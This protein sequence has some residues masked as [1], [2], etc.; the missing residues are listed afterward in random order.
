MCLKNTH[1]KWGGISQ[2]FHW[3]MFVILV[4]LYTIAYIMQDLPNDETKWW[5]YGIHKEVGVTML[6]LVAARLWW[7]EANPIPLDST[8]APHWQNLL[9]RA[10][11]I[12]LYILLF[13]F[14]LSGL[15]MSLLGGHNVNYFGLFTIPALSEDSTPVGS[16]LHATHIY[17]SYLL[18]AFVA[19]HIAAG[20][21]HHFILKDTILKRM[22]PAHS[23][24]GGGD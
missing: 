24:F 9:G 4:G 10:N 12:I 5:L 21:Y 7:R 22:L 14:P 11:V 13:T 17:C 1:H 8:K 6:I 3:G 20:L 23:S 18:I 2:L 15:L 16:L 19:A